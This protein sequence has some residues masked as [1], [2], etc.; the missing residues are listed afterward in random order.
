MFKFLEFSNFNI[1]FWIILIH[2]HRKNVQVHLLC[3][4]HEP[5]VT[6][7]RENGFKF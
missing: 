5:P 6:E 1:Y 3:M 7:E 4:I 2:E